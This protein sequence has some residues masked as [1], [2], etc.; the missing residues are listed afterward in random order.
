MLYV[1]RLL[2]WV[3][4]SDEFFEESFEPKAEQVYL[5]GLGDPLAEAQR[6]SRPCEH[7]A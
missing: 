2:G 7:A 6:L 4:G 5:F 1:K 3:S